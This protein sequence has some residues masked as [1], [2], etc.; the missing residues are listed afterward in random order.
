LAGSYGVKMDPKL[1][2]EIINK[3]LRLP[4]LFKGFTHLR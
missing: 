2:K 4:K 3:E 1:E